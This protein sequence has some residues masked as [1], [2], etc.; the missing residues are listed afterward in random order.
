MYIAYMQLHKNGSCLRAGRRS[1]Q[2]SQ[3][4]TDMFQQL[5]DFDKSFTPNRVYPRSLLLKVTCLGILKLAQNILF[6]GATSLTSLTNT[7]PSSNFNFSQSSMPTFL[8]CPILGETL[9]P[10]FSVIRSQISWLS[11]ILSSDFVEKQW[12]WTIGSFLP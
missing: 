1:S 8:P 4:Q 9:Y 12:T 3:N 11:T 10:N 7:S 5:S 6:F 2:N